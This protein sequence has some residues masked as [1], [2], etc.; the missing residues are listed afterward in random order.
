M[1]GIYKVVSLK[2]G[3]YHTLEYSASHDPEV[4]YFTGGIGNRKMQ[5]NSI[6]QSRHIPILLYFDLSP[7][8]RGIMDSVEYGT[9]YTLQESY[10]H[11]SYM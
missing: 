1:V 3:L 2:Q 4:Q 8:S 5:L 10:M 9:H 11:S 6:P 7:P